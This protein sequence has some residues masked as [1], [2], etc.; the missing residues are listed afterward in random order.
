L[1]GV[2]LEPTFGRMSRRG[3]LRIAALA[4]AALA[5]VV[6]A[7]MHPPEASAGACAAARATPGSVG[8]RGTVHATLCLLNAQRRDH[9]LKPLRLNSH[10]SRAALGHSRDMVRRQYFA[11]ISPSG[12]TFVTRIRRTGYLRE[13]RRWTIGENLAWGSEAW[14]PWSP[15]SAVRA[16]MHSPG[17]RANILR[18]GFREVGIGIVPAHMRGGPAAAIYTTEFGVTG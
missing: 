17:H 15:L 6:P 13:A 9:D 14:R 3:R 7:T 5:V 16:W 11:H 12:T 1:E 4:L 8:T 18:P 2:A 10:L